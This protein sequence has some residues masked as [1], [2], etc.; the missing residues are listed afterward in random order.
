[1]SRVQYN[2]RSSR[3]TQTES[4]ELSLYCF[5]VESLDQLSTKNFSF[6]SCLRVKS[7]CLTVMDMLESIN[8]QLMGSSEKF[9]ASLKAFEMRLFDINS[10]QVFKKKLPNNSFLSTDSQYALLFYCTLSNTNKFLFLH[11]LSDTKIFDVNQYKDST[12]AEFS[13][14]VVT[15]LPK[16]SSFNNFFK[17]IDDGFICLYN[18]DV[19]VDFIQPN[20]IVIPSLQMTLKDIKTNQTTVIV[21]PFYGDL[22]QFLASDNKL[23]I[24]KS[25]R[26]FYQGKQ[27]IRIPQPSDD[28]FDIYLYELHYSN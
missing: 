23:D 8:R 18:S 16:N 11:P 14:S 15:C 12:I 17:L 22:E 13:R 24:M 10:R 6:I 7:K 4:N 1:M 3:P 19:F 5:R 9:P 20:D 21:G 2:L 28:L 27:M 25:T 26:Y